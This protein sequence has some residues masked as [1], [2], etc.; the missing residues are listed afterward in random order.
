MRQPVLAFITAL[1]LGVAPQATADENPS[2]ECGEALSRTVYQD[3]SKVRSGAVELDGIL[4]ALDEAA[5]RCPGNE[6]ALHYAAMAHFTKANL[7]NQ[8]KASAEE[9]SSE[10]FKAFD[11]SQAYWT[12]YDRDQAETTNTGRGVK[13]LT[14][15][16][17]E[18]GDL[19]KDLTT[20]LLNLHFQKDQPHPFITADAPPAAC[21]SA[22]FR[23]VLGTSSWR[24]NNPEHSA[25]AIAFARRLADACPMQRTGPDTFSARLLH[26]VLAGMQVDYAYDIVESDPET[27]RRM[28]AEITAYRDAVLKPGE[29]ENYLWSEFDENRLAD[30]EKKLPAVVTIPTETVDPLVSAGPVAVEDWFKA[31]ADEGKVRDSIGQTFNAYVAVKGQQGFA[32]AVSKM[33]GLAL[34]APDVT[35]A[36]NQVYEV[37]SSYDKGHWRSNDTKDVRLMKVMYEWLKDYEP[38]PAESATDS[39]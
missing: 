29:T 30:L 3:V 12:L 34:K 32:N 23:D 8:E 7:L 37:A 22:Y 16:I 39:Q 1:M 25:F 18:S 5:A 9:V 2:P 27:A 28:A 31:G 24:L 13:M 14:V 38:K 35:A 6:F 4:P 26:K 15:P 33:F 19:R 21:S 11:D 20:V 17:D 10:V 36:S